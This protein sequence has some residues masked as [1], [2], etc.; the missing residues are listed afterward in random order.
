MSIG[1]IVTLMR[2]AVTQTISLIA[3]VL[4]VA[5]IVGLIIAIL[6]AV[7]SI[8]EQ[9][10]TFLPKLLAILFMIALL[11]GTMMAS[12]SEYKIRLFNQIPNLARQ[13]LEYKMFDAVL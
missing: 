7:T 4:I 3:P 10:L 2:G 5:L 6:Q 13:K 8:Q 11:G 1:E 12:L 9:T